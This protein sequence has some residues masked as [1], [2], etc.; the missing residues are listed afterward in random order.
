MGA[1]VR[2]DLKTE[3]IYRL[4]MQGLSSYKIGRMLG[5]CHST[6][7]HRLKQYDKKIM[8]TCKI[9]GKEFPESGKRVTCSKE[10][11]DIYRAQKEIGKTYEGTCAICGK[12]FA[13]K[14]GNQK[15]CSKECAHKRKR[16]LQRSLRERKA[17]G[18]VKERINYNTP[19][20]V[21]EALSPED[22]IK[23]KLIRP[24]SFDDNCDL[25]EYA[26]KGKSPQWIAKFF[27]REIKS[28]E[29]QLADMRKSG[30]YERIRKVMQTARDNPQVA[31][32]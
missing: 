28:V 25:I 14:H 20:W 6:V 21:L 17:N 22:K 32:W 3:E 18:E 16:Q 8:K 23:Y 7:D 10:C 24:Y 9:C 30:K 11:E 2:E 1:K 12:V 31:R 4:K 15:T 19:Q 13:K 27:M 5:C 26:D 29:D